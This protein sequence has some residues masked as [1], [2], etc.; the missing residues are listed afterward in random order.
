[1]RGAAH[2]R[3]RHAGGA[4]GYRAGGARRLDSFDRRRNEERARMAT[5]DKAREQATTNGAGSGAT[6]AVENPATGETIAH[7]PDLGAEQIAELARKARAAQPES[8]ALGFDARGDVLRAMRN[9]LVTNRERMTQTIVEETGKTV[10]DAQTREV[11]LTADSLNFW[12]KK[13]E[14]YLADERIRSHSLFTLGRKLYLRYKPFGLV[15]VI[16][17]W[18]YPLSNS[19][20]DCIPALMAGNAVILKPS[21]VTPLTSLFVEEGMR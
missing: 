3:A 21:E 12:A 20:A 4:R 9:W 6:I 11:F 1:D 19:F 18:N 10:E 17:P 5:V 13:A 15:G 2:R 16:G 8:A 14:K 7:V